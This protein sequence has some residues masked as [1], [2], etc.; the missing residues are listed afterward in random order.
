MSHCL[1]VSLSVTNWIISIETAGR[2][3]LIFGTESTLHLF[4]TV[5]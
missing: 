5:F 1:C 3:E 2:I 4:Y